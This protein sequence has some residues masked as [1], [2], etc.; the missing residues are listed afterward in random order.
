MVS[1]R[2]VVLLLATVGARAAPHQGNRDAVKTNALLG[3]WTLVEEAVAE[4]SE[5]SSGSGGGSGPN[6]LKAYCSG[7]QDGVQ[8]DQKVK[9]DW[10]GFGEYYP[11]EVK[12]INDDG[13][14]DILYDDGWVEKNIEEE[15]VKPVDNNPKNMKPNDD[16]ACQLQDD[17]EQVKKVISNAFGEVAKFMASQ[18]AGGA[19]EDEAPK[20]RP[21]PVPLAGAPS[22]A[23]V[24]PT[25]APNDDLTSL[26]AQLA[27]IDREIAELQNSIGEKDKL[28][29]QELLEDA[30]GYPKT[31]SV[32][33][34][35]ADIRQ[36][37]KRRKRELQR[38]KDKSDRQD[39][40]LATLS[41]V[42][43]E[44]IEE[45]IKAIDMDLAEMK[46]KRDR[47]EKKDELDPELRFGVDS[48]LKQGSKLSDQV[49]NLVVAAADMGKDKSEKAREA[50]LDAAE[51]VTQAVQD[52]KKGAKQLDSGVHP[53]GDKWW[54]YRYERSY[55]EA[56]LMVI[57]S[58]LMLLWERLYIYMR[59]KAYASSAAE[60]HSPV[61]QG[62]M[63]IKWLEYCAGELMVCLLVFLTVWVLAQ[64]GL[65]DLF[66]HFFKG[67]P[68]HVPSSGKEYR[69]MVLD[70]CVILF[71][72][73]VFYFV[74]VLSIVH[75]TT[76]KLSDWELLDTQGQRSPSRSIYRLATTPDQFQA[77]KSYF[78]RNVKNDSINETFPFWRYLRLVVRENVD[79]MFEF[80]LTFWFLIV[81]TFIAF[82]CVHRFLHIG[83]IRI[84]MV[85]LCLMVIVLAAMVFWIKSI[86]AAVTSSDDGV[87]AWS[88]AQ[89]GSAGSR[90]AL[91]RKGS[92]LE[93]ASQ[94]IHEKIPTEYIVGVVVSYVLFF[95]CYGAARIVCQKWMWQ[96]YF[97]P[98]LG[99]TVTTILV[100]MI[101]VFLVAPIIP[102]FA[103]AMAMPPY[104]DPSN[105]AQ[106]RVIVNEEIN[107]PT[108][109]A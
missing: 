21:L 5:T 79:A 64:F 15:A 4:E 36:K 9:A 93:Q 99:L 8:E 66:K 53:N 105:E 67:S 73:V 102:V 75:A 2:L 41:P 33:D 74:L 24:I 90:P 31:W 14:V 100:A 28:I 18:R 83:Y 35:I 3:V 1:Q 42:S 94:N 89:T 97:W 20:P 11:G 49:A 45:M 70:V 29:E 63:Y 52:V 61:V 78:I 69:L 107:N 98:V 88:A 26:W 47:L 27:Q 86:N 103:A 12:E 39:A 22:P 32:E 55:I 82:M 101:F 91:K 85:L 25:E 84:M 62:T 50:M 104:I 17:I 7:A 56:F 38:L 30:G 34:Q 16:P 59:R 77:L 87:T 60:E 13:T 95:L 72:S 81:A 48:L 80:G 92:V 6:T 23:G 40:K 19:Q 76:V 96:L 46:R 71:F 65:W 68:F 58:I 108:D 43:L 106:I 109:R 57:V 10:K 37:L 51:E 44:A 54:R